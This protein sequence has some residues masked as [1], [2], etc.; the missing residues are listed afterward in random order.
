MSQ[1]I[2]FDWR[3]L[4]QADYAQ[5]SALVSSLPEQWRKDLKAGERETLCRL[6]YL[7]W[8]Y[9]A[10]SGRGIGYARPSEAWL[11]K[12][13]G[14]CERTVRRYL[15][16]LKDAGLLEWR[17]RMTKTGENTS[18]LYTIGKNF[19]AMLYARCRGK[20]PIKPVRTKMSADNLKKGYNAAP[21]SPQALYTPPAWMNERERPPHLTSRHVVEFAP[22]PVV[23]EKTVE[24]RKAALLA[25]AERLKARGL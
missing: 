5:A 19:L 7:C 8:H 21:E 1:G 18:N 20:S 10:H 11:A 15:V 25:Q 14:K 23:E 24:D 22:K 2:G 3:S 17:H 12:V 16:V 6:I 9:A 4:G 13:V